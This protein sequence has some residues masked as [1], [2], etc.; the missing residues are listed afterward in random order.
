MCDT[1][2]MLG[3]WNF[4]DSRAADWINTQSAAASYSYHHKVGQAIAPAAP[5]PAALANRRHGL[6]VRR[7]NVSTNSMGAMW[8]RYTV[9]G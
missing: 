4:H 6:Q 5:D 7:L 1:F 2:L 8:S 3:Y 9:I